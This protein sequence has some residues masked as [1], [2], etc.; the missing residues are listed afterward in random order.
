M[1]GRV[2]LLGMVVGLLAWGTDLLLVSGEVHSGLL[3]GLLGLLAAAGGLLG[4]LAGLLLALGDAVAR[5]L[6]Q[7]HPRLVRAAVDAVLAL[8]VIAQ[9]GRKVFA[10]K[11]LAAS[12]VSSAGPWLFLLAALAGAVVASVALRALRARLRGRWRPA[13]LVA[14]LGLAAALIA[15][16]RTQPI[17]AYFYLHVSALLVAAIPLLVALDAVLPRAPAWAAP[18]ALACAIALAAVANP[19]SSV[20]DRLLLYDRPLI[21]GRVTQGVRLAWDRDRDGFS[22]V[23]GGG[24]CDDGDPAV[25]PLALERPGGVDEDCDG[26]DAPPAEP[27]APVCHGPDAAPTRAALRGA[28]LLIL[29][30]DALRADRLAAPPDTSPVPTLQALARSGVHLR[31]AFAPATSTSWVIPATLGGR[32][33]LTDGAPTLVESLRAAG[34]HTGMAIIDDTERV[35]GRLLARF[36]G[37]ATVQTERAAVSVGS[38]VTT[39]TSEDLTDA[40]LAWAAAAPPDQPLALVVHTM[41]AHQWY[42]IEDP[43]LDEAGRAGDAARYDAI[44]QRI[45]ASVATLLGGLRQRGPLLTVVLADHGEGLGSRGIPTHGRHVYPVLSHVPLIVAG[46]GLAPRSVDATVGLV[47]VAPTLA[48]LLSLPPIP[49]AEGQSLVPLLLGAPAEACERPVFSADIVQAG[50]AWRD[51]M[52]TVMPFAN[53]TELLD[54]SEPPL[55]PGQPAVPRNR[56]AQEPEVAARLLGWLRWRFDPGAANPVRL[57]WMP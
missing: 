28:N 48:D 10:G 16:E 9:L 2:A 12:A 53:V 37:V 4:L 5:R 3:A 40:A 22:P 46:P 49:G 52:L 27:P 8:P 24:D 30:V 11:G 32:M 7:R 47:D 18:T 25:H 20:D 35:F 54:L 19:T 34:Y 23:F 39:W 6:P 21:A 33:R 15:A 29:V 56:L 51:R 55:A 38:G 26:A 17:D 13:A 41:D 57:P 36:D 44:L 42:R 45:D 14:A 1:P 31:R 43:A 50:V